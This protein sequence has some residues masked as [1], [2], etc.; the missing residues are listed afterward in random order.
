VLVDGAV[1]VVVAVVVVFP[2]GHAAQQVLLVPTPPPCCWHW[3]AELSMLQTLITP[4]RKL[5]R[6]TSGFSTQVR[7]GRRWQKQFSEALDYKMCRPGALEGAVQVEVAL[8]DRDRR[9]DLQIVSHAVGESDRHLVRAKIH[10]E[11]RDGEQWPARVRREYR[12]LCVAQVSDVHALERVDLNALVAR[13]HVEPPPPHRIE[14]FELQL[15]NHGGLPLKASR[16]PVEAVNEAG[17]CANHGHGP[18]YRRCERSAERGGEDSLRQAVREGRGVNDRN[19]QCDSH[20]GHVDAD[21]GNRIPSGPGVPPRMAID[22]SWV[23][24]RPD[25]SADP[26]GRSVPARSQLTRMS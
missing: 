24:L 7:H 20:D 4:S 25:H 6:E 19:S 11:V 17:R 16:F 23:G 5:V 10:R 15:P 12:G 3:G 1:A 26:I 2:E 13:T 14:P 21:G 22:P 8:Q 18:S 9:V